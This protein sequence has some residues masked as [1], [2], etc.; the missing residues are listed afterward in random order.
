MGRFS[1]RFRPPPVRISRAQARDQQQTLLRD[2]ARTARGAGGFGQR[3][4]R[5][6]SV[7]V[8]LRIDRE[9][10]TRSGALPIG[11]TRRK[12]GYAPIPLA[13]ERVIGEGE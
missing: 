6:A 2:G 1:T 4:A 7:P 5:F 3:E 13:A 10:P 9:G 8:Q 11:T 12:R